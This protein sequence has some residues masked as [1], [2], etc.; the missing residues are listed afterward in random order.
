MTLVLA[1]GLLR[2][3]QED[4]AKQ[5][6][7]SPS[8]IQRI[9]TRKNRPTIDNCHAIVGAFQRNGLIGLSLEMIDEFSASEV[10]A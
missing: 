2:W 6:G 4:L 5:A 7:L 10:V 9:E 1:R 8:T 3:N